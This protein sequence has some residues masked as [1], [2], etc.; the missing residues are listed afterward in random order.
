MKKTM[1]YRETRW[2]EWLE[3]MHKDVECTFGYLKG[4]FIFLRG[5]FVYIGLMLVTAP[6][7]YVVLY[8]I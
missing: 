2:S 3:L 7:K 8:T 4:R 6:A 5:S 1:F